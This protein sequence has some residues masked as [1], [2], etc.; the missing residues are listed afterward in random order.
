[1]PAAAGAPKQG[2]DSKTLLQSS[3]KRPEKPRR[4]IRTLGRPHQFGENAL[5]FYPNTS[6]QPGAL[7]GVQ[8]KRPSPIDLRNPRRI[9]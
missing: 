9:E 8:V 2:Q 7:R 6:P 1:M 5:E 3:H 4:T